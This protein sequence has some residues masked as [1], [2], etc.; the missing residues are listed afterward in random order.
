MITEPDQARLKV[1]ER[2]AAKKPQMSEGELDRLRS[3]K[4]LSAEV[5]ARA[6]AHPSWVFVVKV[7]PKRPKAWWVG[8]FLRYFP[9]VSV[10]ELQDKRL[11]VCTWKV[12]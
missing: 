2:Y 1:L 8:G 11:A 12:R 9:G 7:T 6:D 5:K 3:P 10:M 4:R